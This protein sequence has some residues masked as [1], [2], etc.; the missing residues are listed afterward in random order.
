M[1]SFN[2]TY[3]LAKADVSDPAAIADLFT[4]V[5]AKFGKIDIVIANAGRRLNMLLTGGALF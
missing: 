5:L 4:Q 3:E 2:I 1:D